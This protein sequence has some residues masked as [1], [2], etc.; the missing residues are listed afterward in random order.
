MING[1]SGGGG[2]GGRPD[3]GNVRAPCAAVNSEGAS[4]KR[5]VRIFFW[6]R[7]AAVGIGST[8]RGK[9][10]TMVS[11]PVCTEYYGEHILAIRN[12]VSMIVPRNLY[13]VIGSSRS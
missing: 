11:L 5:T 1:Q 12:I 3:Q 10:M 7:K 2:G 6:G 9:E 4:T 8:W 13:F